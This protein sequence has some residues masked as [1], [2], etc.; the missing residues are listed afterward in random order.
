MLHARIGKVLTRAPDPDDTLAADAARHADAGSD[1]ATCAAA[2]I[3]A[4]RRCLRLLA[5]REAEEH[6]ELGRAHARKLA[7]EVR[8]PLEIQLI[9]VLIHP[10]LRFWQPGDLAEDLTELCAGA[11]RLGLDAELATGLY[12]LGFT[13]QRGWRD[14]PRATAL[15]ERVARMLE[16]ARQPDVGPL[17]DGARCLAYL[18][19]DME[20]TRQLFDQLGGLGDLVTSSVQ[21]QWGLGLVQAWAGQVPE[22]RAAFARAIELATTGGDHW[23][24][25][26]CT[27]RLAV[28]EI[29][30]GAH[31]TAMALSGQLGPLAAKLGEGGSEAAYA[32]AVCVLA[33]LT[34][35]DDTGGFDQAI[36]ELDRLDAGFLTPHLLGIAA[37]AEYRAGDLTTADAHA[38]R[39]LQVSAATGKPFEAARARALL[40]CISASNQAPGVAIEQLNSETVDDGRLPRHVVALRR[41]AE[42][43]AG[44]PLSNR[45]EN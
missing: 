22:A 9:H 21:Y 25:F 26:E 20:R 31:P 30:A 27:A 7:P 6:V 43:L 3:R 8:I 18:E 35:G 44:N 14:I 34:G 2:C 15:L 1:S 12:L 33:A 24:V 42:A 41:E 16:V 39:A 45:R 17:H 40:A 28:L 37:E 4:A 5:Y 19:F 11:Q 13:Y 32:R 38:A 29:E 10:G 23:P 36:A